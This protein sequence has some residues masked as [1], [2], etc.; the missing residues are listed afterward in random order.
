[1]RHVG[2][3]VPIGIENRATDHACHHRRLL[4]GLPDHYPHRVLHIAP[5]VKKS[6]RAAAELTRI[7][8]P[9]AAL[10]QSGNAIIATFALDGPERCSGLPVVRYDAAALAKELG[11]SF[12]LIDSW[13]ERHETPVGSSQSFTWAL[14]EKP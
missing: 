2:R 9:P 6:R 5:G 4:G 11:P 7:Q 3:H 14:F 1:M 8:S 12:V 13:N 10:A